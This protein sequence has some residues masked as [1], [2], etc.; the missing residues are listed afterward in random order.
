MNGRLQVN[1]I[2]KGWLA[3]V[4][5]MRGNLSTPP[6]FYEKYPN[7]EGARNKPAINEHELRS[8]NNELSEI[9]IDVCPFE[10]IDTMFN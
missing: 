6:A 9:G 2:L 1:G 4:D 5:G 10:D 7:Y 8:G 3:G